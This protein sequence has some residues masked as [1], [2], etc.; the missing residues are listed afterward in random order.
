MCTPL[1]GVIFQSIIIII[2]II[3]NNKN[4]FYYYNNKRYPGFMENPYSHASPFYHL[5][6]EK[7]IDRIIQIGLRDLTP[8]QREIKEKFNKKLSVIEMP[9]LFGNDALQVISKKCGEFL[10]KC[11]DEKITK[12]YVSIDVDVLDP[13]YAPGVSHIEPGGLTSREL[14]SA[15]DILFYD[16]KLA[17]ECII[18][19]DVVE[20]NPRNDVNFVTAF[21][22]A[23]ILRRLGA[24]IQTRK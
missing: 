15:L 5:L 17:Q 10:Q 11:K 8:E 3:N 4:N 1:L 6:E 2:I 24:L 14:F 22:S 12:F 9:E 16:K 21:V 7:A 13:A 20:Y 23:R 19:C 18:G